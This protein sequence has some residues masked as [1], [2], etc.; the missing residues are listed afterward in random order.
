[1][2][3]ASRPKA[4]DQLGLLQRLAKVALDPLHQ[5][6]PLLDAIVRIGGDKDR[7]DRV[8]RF[9]QMSIK[10][11]ARYCGHVNIGDQARGG[12]EFGGCEE[13]GGGREHRDD[14]TQ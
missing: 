6:A 14:V 7:W 13:L 11:D 5:H 9:D 3:R 4:A 10:L 12:S 8:A 2:A 1:M